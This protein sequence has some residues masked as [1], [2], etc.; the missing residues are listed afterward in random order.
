MNVITA[1]AAT[2]AGAVLALTA[3][4]PLPLHRL[5][6][7]WRIRGRFAD[8]FAV[9]WEDGQPVGRRHFLLRLTNGMPLL[10]LGVEAEAAGWSILAV[11]GLAS[12]AVG[13]PPG[14]ASAEAVDT[15]IVAF[16]E[17]FRDPEAHWGVVRLAA[18][19]RMELE[20]GEALAAESPPVAWV[21]VQSGSLHAPAGE[22]V[23]PGMPAVPCTAAAP[24]RAAEESTLVVTTTAALIGDAGLQT[25][26]VAWHAALLSRTQGLIAARMASLTAQL[27]SSDRATRHGLTSGLMRLA[28]EAGAESDA[29]AI[30]DDD[31][32][33]IARVAGELG[34]SPRGVTEATLQLPAGAARIDAMIDEAGLRG[35]R[36]LLRTGWWGWKTGPLIGMRAGDGTAVALLP[37]GKRTRIWTA[38]AASSPVVDA[39]MAGALSPTAWMLY[40]SLPDASPKPWALASFAFAGGGPLGMRLMVASLAGSVLG[41]GVPLATGVLVETV[42][43]ASA[44]GDIAVLALGL[45]AAAFGQ[46]A[47]NIVRA[48]ILLQLEGRLDLNSQPAL[49]DR[50]LRLHPTFFRGFAAG[51]LADR[52]MGVQ[53]MR[54]LITGSTLGALFAGLMSLVNLSVMFVCSARLAMVGLGVAVAQ[55]GAGAVLAALQLRRERVLANRRGQAE[56]FVLQCIGGLAKLRT[57]S[58]ADRAFA[59]WARLFAGQ[60]D[61]F[62]AVQRT[63][64]WQSVVPALLLPAGTALLF[65]LAAGLAL[66]APGAGVLGLAAWVAFSAA[67]GQLTAGLGFMVEAAGEMLGVLPL[68]ERA[69]PLLEAMPETAAPARPPGVVAGAIAFSG[70]TFGY[71]PGAPPVLQDLSFSIRPGEFVAIVGPSGCGKST[72][73]RLMLGFEVPQAGEI[74]FEGSSLATLDVVALRRQIGVVLQNGRV[75]PGSL[76][77]NIGGG[78]PIALEDGWHAARMAGLE[79]DIKAMPMG[80][81][82][83]LTDGGNT[84]SGG[85]RQRLMIAR[86][87]A[88]RPKILLLDE[89]TSALDNRTQAIVT[90]AVASLGLTRVV[91][92]HRLSTIA[93][94]DR[95]L[96]LD[97]GRL[98]QSG[99]FAELAN[100]PGL[101]ADLARRQLT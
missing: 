12:E 96:V 48:I 57:A 61:A 42:I 9:R 69:R 97:G 101:F 67:F 74:L 3:D 100:A 99:G 76:I 45:A 71:L 73:L 4:T 29:A 82:T 94:V 39:A 72:I 8:L 93:R 38:P 21:K 86:A 95:V 56:S 2:G 58:A 31:L 81:H 14:P 90:D 6:G 78:R 40:R 80:M 5:E 51:D 60:R 77:E 36:V 30:D 63:R 59:L 27:G 66:G 15:W 18:T 50:M 70:I 83:M 87:L 91:I 7:I 17:L 47:V 24:L 32:R 92:A 19:G 10:G 68:Y 65:T 33:V 46:A 23:Q 22:V 64:A 84:L 43:P 26:L 25:A 11:G 16:D 62:V 88:R 85:Q 20:A 75:Q 1:L 34:M 44:G 41:L 54:R 52:V 35:R 55:A 49:F 28:G 53:E 98:V 79:A 37:D 13:A 89:A